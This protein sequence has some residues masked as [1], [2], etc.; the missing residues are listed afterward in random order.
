M[1]QERHRR[2]QN[3]LAADR[4][5]ALSHHGGSDPGPPSWAVADAVQSDRKDRQRAPSHTGAKP[6]RP[7]PAGNS[8]VSTL[9]FKPRKSSIRS[10]P[11]SG[12]LK[13][14]K[15]CGSWFAYW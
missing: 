11:H 9:R 7:S 12:C 2:L 15:P 14:R 5:M 13:P 3:P 10:A 6:P 8:R 1:G 4:A